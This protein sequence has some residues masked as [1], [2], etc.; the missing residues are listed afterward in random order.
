MKQLQNLQNQRD[1]ILGAVNFGFTEYLK[2]M[3]WMSDNLIQKT[4]FAYTAGI[5]S[6]MTKLGS[7]YVYAFICDHHP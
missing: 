1:F 5:K 2:E 7:L 4:D 3:Y 6:V